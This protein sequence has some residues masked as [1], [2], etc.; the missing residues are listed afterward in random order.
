MTS[1]SDNVS[2]ASSTHEVDGKHPTSPAES[3]AD[4]NMC[5]HGNRP[6]EPSS[7]QGHQKQ[8]HHKRHKCH[9]HHHHHKHRKHRS[10]SR[11]QENK[12][13]VTATKDCSSAS[14]VEGETQAGAKA[15]T[16]RKSRHRGKAKS[17]GQQS[18]VAA[19]AIK[20]ILVT[21]ET[22]AFENKAFTS[23]NGELSDDVK[24]QE[25]EFKD[26]KDKGNEKDFDGD[27]VF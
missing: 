5:P 12:S 2:G 3:E 18:P 4:R 22:M 23:D 20:E 26:L 14:E 21:K 16:V 17:N 7:N 9:H 27:E 15:K 19:M 11:S 25:S 8:G 10:R 1:S 24:V 13:L 6:R